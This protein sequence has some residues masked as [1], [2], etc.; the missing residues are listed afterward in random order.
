MD[1]S[2]G[3]DFKKRTCIFFNRCKKIIE[4]KIVMDPGGLTKSVDPNPDPF[5]LLEAQNCL[6]LREAAK[7]VF[8]GGPTTQAFTPPPRLSGH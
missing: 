2:A 1:Q 8:F 3:M 6:A 5:P 7:K 4:K